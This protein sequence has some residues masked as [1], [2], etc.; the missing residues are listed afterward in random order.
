MGTNQGF[1][2]VGVRDASSSVDIDRINK[3]VFPDGSLIPT[4]VDEVEIDYGF[5]FLTP[6]MFAPAGATL[7]DGTTQP[8]SD[9][10]ANLAAAQVDFSFVT[11]LTQETDWACLTKMVYEAL[12]YPTFEHAD[13]NAYLNKVMQIPAGKYMLGADTLLIRN[14]SGVRMEGAGR[15]AT[16]LIAD[17]CVFRTD[18]LWYSQITGVDFANTTTT[19]VTVDIDGNIPGHPYATRG[20]QGNTFKDCFF[21]G[22]T[23]ADYAFALTRLGNPG[24]GAQGSE[25]LF[26]NCHFNSTIEASFYSTGFNALQ[27]TFIGGN[28]QGHQKHGIY[29]EA[30]SVY[31]LS[32]GF[33]STY[34]Y[35][36]IINDGFDINANFGGVGDRITIIGC[37]SESLPFY[38]GGSSQPPVLI[39]NTIS[40]TGGTTTWAATTAYTLNQM[41]YKTSATLGT[42]MYRVSTAGTSGGSEP[43]WPD[44]GT[45]ADG[46]G[47]LVWTMTDYFTV[48]IGTSGAPILLNNSFNEAGRIRLGSWLAES[49]I[50]VNTSTALAIRKYV[51]SHQVIF[52]DTT[53]GNQTITLHTTLPLSAKVPDGTTVTIKKVTTDANTVTLAYSGGNGGEAVTLP[54]GSISY[55]T[56]QYSEGAGITSKWWIIS[57]EPEMLATS[58]NTANRI[59]KRNS[60]GVFNIS[61]VELEA[62]NS[63][64]WIKGFTNEEITLNTGSTTTDSTADLLPANSIIEAVVAVIDVTITTATT[65]TI[66][67]PTTAT[68][69]ISSF[70]GMGAGNQRVGLNHQKGS[71]TT[72]AAGPTQTSAAKVR[73]TTDVNPGAGKIRVVVFYSQFIAPSA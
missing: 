57:Q 65:I 37:R 22:A 52:T 72:D 49:N 45:V 56:L 70:P 12:G 16:K 25:N 68:R 50:T 58:A 30:G 26:L 46:G 38:R 17:D 69:F 54:G 61:G 40:S 64:K 44:S 62:G 23:I 20:V 53:S 15:R 29:I 48:D 67:D 63:A 2:Y 36:Q 31:L 1:G 5:G 8:L 10:Y 13:A 24:G 33:Q 19:T 39:G 51:T 47:T 32:V 3:L 11:A 35:T 42:K 73:I 9:F 28:F 55:V 34:G 43:T 7:G 66:G 27:N 14:A 6:K 71:V 60:S 4:G 59:V 21:D 41:I 18:G